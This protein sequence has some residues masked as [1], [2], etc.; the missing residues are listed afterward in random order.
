MTDVYAD[1]GELEAPEFEPNA[2]PEPPAPPTAEERA[3][4]MGWHPLEEYRGPPRRW[5]DAE[6]FIKRGEEELPILRQQNRNLTERFALQEREMATL[7]EEARRLTQTVR[8]NLELQRKAEERGYQRGLAELKAARR[9]AIQEGDVA[10]AEAIDNEIDQLQSARPTAPAPAR[11]PE[12]AK[13]EIRIDPAVTQ[14]VNE[15][16][17]FNADTALNKAMIAQHILVQSLYPNWSMDDQLYEAKQRLIRE[18]PHKFP[19]EGEAQ[20]APPTPRRPMA[21]PVARPSAPAAQPRREATG[22]DRI[23]ENERVAAKRAFEREQDKQPWITPEMY[24]SL[25]LGETD[26]LTARRKLAAKK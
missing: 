8:E 25:Y 23:P 19:N 21:A 20:V 26:P 9:A 22:W 2:P 5:V 3:R 24:I 17:W 10:R 6:T 1:E 16:P 13:P 4:S 18:F 11:E 15:N 14:F 7:R 12:P